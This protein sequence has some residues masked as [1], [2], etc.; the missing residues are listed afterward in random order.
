MLFT[1]HT[2]LL[3]VKKKSYKTIILPVE[4]NVK[5]KTY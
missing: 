1:F 2:V 4:K 5:K 3:M